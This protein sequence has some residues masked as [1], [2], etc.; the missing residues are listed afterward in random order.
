MRVS[1][2]PCLLNSSV[3]LL[4][5]L[6]FASSL[7]ILMHVCMLSCFS[8]IWLFVTLW[9]VAHQAPLS[10]GILQA[11]ILEW[12]VIPFSP[13]LPDPGI[14]PE[15]PASTALTGRFFTHWATWEAL[16]YTDLCILTN[17]FLFLAWTLD[18]IKFPYYIL[19]R[20]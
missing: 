14:K 7:Y 11:R 15:S 13:D 3:H 20:L 5:W 16:L 17:Q 8:H 6:F 18:F 4:W 1:Y 9:T 2:F 19:R 12:V 10:M